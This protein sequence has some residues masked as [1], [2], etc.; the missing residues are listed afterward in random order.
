MNV[1]VQKQQHRGRRRRVPTTSL[2]VVME[3]V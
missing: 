3:V 2:H 1:H